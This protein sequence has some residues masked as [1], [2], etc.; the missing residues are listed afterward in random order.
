MIRKIAPVTLVLV[1]IVLSASAA[2]AQT[3]TETNCT[4]S[5]DYGVGRTTNCTSTST[6]TG[7]T[8]SQV[9]QQKQLNDS[10]AQLGG[11]IGMAIARKRA[12]HEQE[13]NDLMA[14]VFCRQNPT[15]SWTFANKPPTPCST[16]ERNVVAYCSVNAKTPICKDVAKLPPAS[17]QV[18]ASPDDQRVT[19]NVVYCQQNPNGT[20]TTG[21][22]EKKL[23]ATRLL[24]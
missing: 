24:T 14:V 7:P 9:E 17:T 13:K 23:A 16:L 22:G 10:A 11:A 21:N 4:T 1:A 19:I 20:V 18:L 3:Q 12:Q 6:P 15:G 5:P 2:S 8:P